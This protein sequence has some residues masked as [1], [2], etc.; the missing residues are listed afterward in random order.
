MD[1]T[2]LR[3]LFYLVEQE[4][5]ISFRV[6]KDKIYVIIKNNRPRS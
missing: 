2:I 3:F 1:F 5:I 6:T 4:I